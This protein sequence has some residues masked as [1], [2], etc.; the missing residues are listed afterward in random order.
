MIESIIRLLAD[1]ARYFGIAGMNP[2][3]ARVAAGPVMDR[4]KFIGA[5]SASAGP[6]SA[7]LPF[8]GKNHAK[9]VGLRDAAITR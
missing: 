9:D 2:A 4:M 3:P 1:S 5:R 8:L 6:L 7:Q